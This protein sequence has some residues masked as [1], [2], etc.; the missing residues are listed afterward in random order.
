MKLDK[1]AILV[2]P[3]FNFEGGENRIRSLFFEAF[4]KN[5]TEK[6]GYD[7]EVINADVAPQSTLGKKF[8][9]RITDIN[10]VVADMYTNNDNVAIEATISCLYGIDTYLM[11]PKKHP[12]GDLYKTAAYF[13][14]YIGHR[15]NHEDILAIKESMENA[16]PVSKDNN[17]WYVNISDSNS[18]SHE[19]FNNWFDSYWEDSSCNNK[20]VNKL[21]R[22]FS[23]ILDGKF[24]FGSP[25][26]DE[27]SR[28]PF[29]QIYNTSH[30]LELEAGASSIWIFANDLTIGIENDT[31]NM[32]LE[33]LRN[34]SEYRYIVPD[35]E[36]VKASVEI[37]RKSLGK[38]LGSEESNC[39]SRLRVKFVAK[40][41]LG[42]E[43][44]MLNSANSDFAAYMLD[45][46]DDSRYLLR[47]ND[48]EAKKIRNKHL[49]LWETGLSVVWK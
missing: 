41:L 22:N 18:S 17:D 2:M 39:L 23:R 4:I 8:H 48:S 38:L 13:D 10:L 44:T 3:F 27:M 16:I 37:L 42:Q 47:L 32:M 12:N 11:A 26:L 31:Q 19:Y 9:D 46:Y 21:K 49:I 6:Y 28:S 43:V 24:E 25:L 30:L 33:N 15:Y 35:D 34:G 36:D 40:Q 7:S 5:V 45:V 29:N 20:F 14:P 1:K